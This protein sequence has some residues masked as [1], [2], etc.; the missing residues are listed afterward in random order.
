VG[1]PVEWERPKVREIDP[2][3]DQI[4]G[5][6]VIRMANPPAWRATPIWGEDNRWA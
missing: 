6:L 4:A 3:G 5:G 2:M 1:L